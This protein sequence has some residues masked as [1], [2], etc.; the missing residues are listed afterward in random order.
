MD[1]FLVS[2]GWL[3]G[4]IAAGISVVGDRWL[5]WVV[6]VLW[7]MSA[8]A[9]L[10]IVAVGLVLALAQFAPAEPVDAAEEIASRVKAGSPQFTWALVLILALLML[11]AVGQ[12][13]W[14]YYI[15]GDPAQAEAQLLRDSAVMIR[16]GFFFA[17]AAAMGL[18]ANLLAL[19]RASALRD[20]RRQAP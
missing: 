20:R 19:A 18:I 5:E 1:L 14:I 13:A 9:Y 10:G 11:L 4:G 8:L 12:V 2:A 7:S 15:D 3:C 16:L 6:W 17:L